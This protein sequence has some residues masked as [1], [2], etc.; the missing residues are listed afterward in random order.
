MSEQPAVT[1][2]QTLPP[3]HQTSIGLPDG[4][5]PAFGDPDDGPE[6]DADAIKIGPSPEDQ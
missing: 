6:A 3:E 4:P 2:P 5:K 1:T